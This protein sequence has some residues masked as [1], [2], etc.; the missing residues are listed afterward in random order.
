MQ[1]YD[2][3]WKFIKQQNCLVYCLIIPL[4]ISS[5]RIHA[6]TPQTTLNIATWGG[7]YQ[8]AQQAAIF[9]PFTAKTGI[10]IATQ[11]YNGGIG[12]LQRADKP[13][14]IDMVEEDALRA[15]DTGLLHEADFTQF[16][17]SG[18]SG[19][20]VQQDFL[21]RSF[22]P[23]SVAQLSFSTVA[24]YSITAY[25]DIK[26]QTIADFFDLQRF[27][28]KR[29]L[30]KEPAVM[31]E[32]ALAANGV[33]LNQIY[34]LLSTERGLQLALKKLDSIR[35]HIVWWEDPDEP[36]N[37]LKSG[38]VAMTSGYNGR[39]FAA[40][41]RNSPIII[42][43]DAQITEKATWV[44]PRQKQQ[45]KIKPEILTFIR[46]ATATRTQA[47]LAEN[48]P[49]GP[50]RYSAFAFIG[51]HPEN[52]QVMSGHLPT[53]PHHLSR[54]LFKDSKWSANTATLRQEAFEQ[55]LKTPMG[56]K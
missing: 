6:D 50:T 23:C 42:L 31:L 33:P 18:P 47:K 17:D 40:Q 7:L 19:E 35:E 52:G 21:P 26:P 55:W 44:I 54:A 9:T 20:S 15:C 14:L 51:K 29:G 36:A 8:A 13:D 32:W 2:T 4:F 10:Q 11:P 24:A 56:R 16:V 43:W 39:L 48:I 28:G 49:Y 25:P 30:R 22:L 53:A 34:D 37:L 1:Q 12:I 46:Y 41:S 45:A 27:P 38:Q 3:P 5:N